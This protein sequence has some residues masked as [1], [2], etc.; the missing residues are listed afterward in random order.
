MTDMEPASDLR[1]LIEYR[2]EGAK[3]AAAFSD[4]TVER[5]HEAGLV[6]DQ[7]LERLEQVVDRVSHGGGL[8]QD[9]ELLVAWLH[10][11]ELLASVREKDLAEERPASA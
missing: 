10:G 8:C 4:V 3:Q 1:C 6:S 11:F 2:P 5:L 7:L 9:E